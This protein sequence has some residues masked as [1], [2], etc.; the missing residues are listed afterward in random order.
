MIFDF[1]DNS[2]TFIQQKLTDS[3]Y[4]VTQLVQDP[5]IARQSADFSK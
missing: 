5:K 4:V 3:H 2:S 1:V